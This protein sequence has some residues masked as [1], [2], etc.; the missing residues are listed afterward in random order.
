[1]TP[2]VRYME[3][4]ERDFERANKRA[5]LKK[6]GFPAAASARYDSKTKRIAVALQS[7]VVIEFP[8]DMAQGLE[9]ARPSELREIVIS[10]S[11]LGL[12]FPRLDADI[13]LPGILE[14]FL[15]SKRWVASENG[16]RGGVVSTVA[17]AAASRANGK[18]GG[19]PKKSR[20]LAAA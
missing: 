7:G 6:A 5:S 15:G 12:H 4:S 13:Y 9:R 16:K 19:R 20:T 1:V 14:G 2:G 11:G 3:I 17:K 8:Y 10:P 18:L